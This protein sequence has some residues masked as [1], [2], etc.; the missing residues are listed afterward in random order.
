[1]SSRRS[2]SFMVSGPGSP[3]PTIHPP[4]RHFTWPTGVMTAA[5]PHA[6]TSVMEPCVAFAPVV[7]ADALSLGVDPEVGGHLK[8]RV[9][10]DPGKKG[11]SELR[12]DQSR[13][14]PRPIDE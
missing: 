11:A 2:R 14:V 5:V 6:K 8:D 4:S 12:G 1:M 3:L 7:D 10:R 9:A 13:R